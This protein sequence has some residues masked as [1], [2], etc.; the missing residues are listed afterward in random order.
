MKKFP[1]RTMTVSVLVACALSVPSGAA[2]AATD[3]P[4]ARSATSVPQSGLHQSIM[5]QQMLATQW[6]I[7]LSH[8]NEIPEQVLVKGDRATQEWLQANRPNSPLLANPGNQPGLGASFWGCSGAI[9]ALIGGNLVGAAKLLKIKRLINDLGGVTQAV[10]IMWGASFSYEK[11]RAAGGAIAAL[12]GEF[13]GISQV[14]SQCF[15]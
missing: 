3:P 11:M 4:T 6:T 13:L 8:I 1:F 2:L 7:A 15:N 10:R 5:S 14:R 9:L 12:A